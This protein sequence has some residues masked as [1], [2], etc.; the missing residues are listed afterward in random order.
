MIS[1][2]KLGY[3]C[4][5]KAISTSEVGKKTVSTPVGG[6]DYPF[7]PPALALG[8]G[9]TFVARTIDKEIKH[10]GG[11]IKESHLHKGTSFVEVYQNLLI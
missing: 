7:N 8:E 10:M 4:S 1:Y 9:G 6:L 2:G 3:L 5:A 11:I